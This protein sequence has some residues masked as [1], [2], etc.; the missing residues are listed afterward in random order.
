MYGIKIKNIRGY[1]VFYDPNIKKFQLKDKAGDVVSQAPTHE[2]VEKSAGKLSKQKFEQT[3]AIHVTKH[4]I[5]AG[6]I[7]SLNP[8]MRQCWISYGD[9]SFHNR[10]KISLNYDHGYF[11]KTN[12]N[13]SIVAAVNRLIME[14][15][16]I[17]RKI[18]E[19]ITYLEKPINVE[20]FGLDK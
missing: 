9:G 2:E 20:F 3:L 4:G 11:Q 13:Q 19:Q 16:E 18:E 7:T 15:K 10:E 6:R 12:H 5:R 17:E 8:E 1:A 14:A